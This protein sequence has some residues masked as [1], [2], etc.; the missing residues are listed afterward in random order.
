M[1]GSAGG[2]LVGAVMNYEPTLFNGIMA[3]VPFVDVVTTMLDEAFRLQQE[4]LTNGEI[5]KRKNITIICFLT[6]LMTILKKR[7]SKYF[8]Y[9]RFSRFSGAILGTCKMDCKIERIKNR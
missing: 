6:L 4:N 9:N 7:L 8:N 3:Q 2:L 5:L 1:G